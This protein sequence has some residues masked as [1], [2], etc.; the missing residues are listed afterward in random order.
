MIEI[1]PVSHD[2]ISKYFRDFQKKSKCFEM[3]PE[4][5]EFSGAYLDDE[6][7][8]YFILQAYGDGDI[9]I[10]QGYLRPEYRHTELAK[11]FMALLEQAIKK[12]GCKRM[13]LGTHNRFKAYLKF[14]KALGYK[15]EHLTFSKNLGD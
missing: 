3:P 15:P 8:G 9:E 10:Y 5:A 14:A 2:T 6:L 11:S 4:E 13:I 12:L 7:V 1:K